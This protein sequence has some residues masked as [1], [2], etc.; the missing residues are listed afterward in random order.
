MAY[1]CIIIKNIKVYKTTLALFN[2]NIVI[3]YKQVA[4]LNRKQ[5][6]HMNC[7]DLSAKKIVG[8]RISNTV[9]QEPTLKFNGRHFRYHLSDS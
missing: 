9:A 7:S 8:K 6:A 2:V 1:S 5:N 3:I 4:R